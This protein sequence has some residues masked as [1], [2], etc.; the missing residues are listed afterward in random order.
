MEEKKK[1]Q[2]WIGKV[3]VFIE[4]IGNSFNRRKRIWWIGDGQQGAVPATQNLKLIAP[5][6]GI[7]LKKFFA[8]ELE[9]TALGKMPFFPT[10]IIIDAQI[11]ERIKEQ[12]RLRS[13]KYARFMRSFRAIKKNDKI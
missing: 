6:H 11:K 10:L 12:E 2:R 4:R 7:E 5:V 9:A 3:A 8:K 1:I 13:E